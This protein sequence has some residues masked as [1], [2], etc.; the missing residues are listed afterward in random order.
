VGQGRFASNCK[1]L[2]ERSTSNET[3]NSDTGLP[4]PLIGSQETAFS[5]VLFTKWGLLYWE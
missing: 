5:V 4:K 1:A 3:S 2:L